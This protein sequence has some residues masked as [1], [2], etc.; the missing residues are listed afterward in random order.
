[1][2]QPPRD[3]ASAI[4]IRNDQ[5]LLVRDSRTRP[6][7]ALPGGGV[8]PGELPVNTVARELLEETSLVATSVD[9]LFDYHGKYNVH[10]VYRVN[11]DG[12]VK[13]QAEIDDYIWWDKSSEDV[14]IFPHVKQI[15]DKLNGKV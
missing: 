14:P 4:V 7:Y 6:S 8:D 2:Q 5:L 1:M 15:L 3:R 11:A 10:H 13:I 9:F 12:D